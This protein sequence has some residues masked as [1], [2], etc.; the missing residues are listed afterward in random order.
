[1][2]RHQY[3]INMFYKGFFK[4][5]APVVFITPLKD[6]EFEENE[7]ARLECEVKLKG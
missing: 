3:V 4:T 2:D 6:V 1:M 7:T 5:D